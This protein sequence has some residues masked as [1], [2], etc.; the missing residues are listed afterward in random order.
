M[1]EIWPTKCDY[2]ITTLGGLIGL[3]SIWRF[4]YLAFQNGGAAF[5]IPYVIISLLC[6][7]PLLI[8]ETGLGQLSRRGPVG[9]WN[10]APAMKGIGIA[11]VFM[12]FFGA[13]YYVIIMVW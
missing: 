4:P 10:F 2:L 7:I 11:S 6:G 3:G 13:L 8:M 9:C 12:S 1:R 5:V